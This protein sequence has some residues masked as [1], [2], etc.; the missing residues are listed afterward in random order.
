[1]TSSR[2]MRQLSVLDQQKET[3]FVPAEKE[4]CKQQT[5]KECNL[6]P[7]SSYYS[8]VNLMKY[9]TPDCESEFSES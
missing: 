6:D 9:R 8:V 2:E 7:F 4:C 5:E 3:D 1:M